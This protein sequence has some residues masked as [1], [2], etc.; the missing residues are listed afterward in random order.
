M[1]TIR[2]A[3]YQRKA[4]PQEVDFHTPQLRLPQKLQGN[5]EVNDITTH[6]Y[7]SIYSVEGGRRHS[8]C[9]CRFKNRDLAFENFAEFLLKGNFELVVECSTT[10]MSTE[11]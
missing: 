7:Y 10:P 5:V 1:T 3:N 9:E 4:A 6:T 8:L 11:D 2:S